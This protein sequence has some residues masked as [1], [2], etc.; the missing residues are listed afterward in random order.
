MKLI[1]QAI[2]SLFRKLERNLE[3]SIQNAQDTADEAKASIIQSDFA[4]NDESQ[5]D[6]VKNRTHWSEGSLEVLFDGKVIRFLGSSNLAPSFA[7]IVGK[8]YTVMFKGEVYECECFDN[9]GEPTIG[10]IRQDLDYSKFPFT[11]FYTNDDTVFDCETDGTYSLKVIEGVVHKLDSIYLPEI[12]TAL[13]NPYALTFTGSASGSYDGSSAK[14]VYIPTAL[15][16][17]NTLTFT[18]SA[19]GSY[20]GSSAKTVNIPFGFIE[21]SGKEALWFILRNG[22]YTK[23]QS[24][25][26]ELLR[27]ALGVQKKEIREMDGELYYFV[28]D[29]VAT[30]AGLI[31]MDGNFY[32][33][34]T[35]GTIITGQ[36]YWVNKLN[37]YKLEEGA[38]DF[39]ESGVMQIYTITN[40][41][42]N[43]NT[44]NTDIYF[45][46]K[47]RKKYIA[48]LTVAE[49]YT[50]S[51]VAIIMGDEDI[52][53]TAYADG[54]ITIE[55]VTGD[56]IITATAEATP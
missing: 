11:I 40:N 42:T 48:N 31:R 52:T 30:G 32:Y 35:T 47:G 53:A 34:K 23:D 6:Y 33:V 39:N 15:K 27:I 3:K 20:N 50:I 18:G 1:L 16:N 36:A 7:L 25:N 29:V 49:G 38:Y 19:S 44:N 8:K 24:E 9:D 28:D 37:G 17:P 21:E 51:S 46:T 10:A 41:L 13:K 4:Q 22:Q 54:V 5:I 14:T 45:T 26:I 43:V 56:I 12:P 55:S 2:K